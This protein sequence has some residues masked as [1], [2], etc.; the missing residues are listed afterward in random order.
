MIQPDSA[1]AQ[2]LD[3]LAAG[4]VDK[5]MPAI[6]LNEADLGA[7]VAYIHDQKAKMDAV[8]GGRQPVDVAEER[9]GEIEVLRR[10]LRERPDGMRP[11]V[12]DRMVLALERV[13]DG[14]LQREADV[15]TRDGDAHQRSPV[16]GGAR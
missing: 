16:L 5:G 14:G 13:D 8:G 11:E 6:D 9:V 7:I 2:I 10:T 12:E 1:V 4:R 15:I 3:T